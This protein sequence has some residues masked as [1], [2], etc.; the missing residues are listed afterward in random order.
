MAITVLAFFYQSVGRGYI[1]NP[2]DTYSTIIVQLLSVLVPVL[3][4]CVGNWCLTSLFEGEGSFKDIFVATSYCLVPLPL[5]I[6]PATLASNWVTTTE[7]SIVTFV[8]TVAFIW[9]GLL[10]IA[11]MSVTHDYSMFKNIITILGTIVAMACIIFI[12]L[13]FSMLLSKLISLVTNLITE[14]QYRM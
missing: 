8:G 11:G 13:L 14:I 10:L 5:L 3:L 2:R 1:F 6:I 4:W 9:V 7:A 12:V